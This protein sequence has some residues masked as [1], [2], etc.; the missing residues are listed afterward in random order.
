MKYCQ[1][2]EPTRRMEHIKVLYSWKLLQML[3]YLEK[4]HG[5]NK[6]SSLFP[7]PVDNEV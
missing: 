6:H 2:Q 7:P 3:D 1:P 4:K 5:T